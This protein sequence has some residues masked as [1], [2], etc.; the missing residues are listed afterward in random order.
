[1]PLT[2]YSNTENTAL[3]ILKRKGY[4]IWFETDLESFCCEKDGWDFT[5]GGAT[6]LLGVVAFHEYH[7]PKE[8]KEYWWRIEEP[9]LLGNLPT[10]PEPF[11]PVSR[12]REN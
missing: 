9:K 3:I 2:A 5:A 7:Q 11:V 12:R 8:F 10:E 4:Q 1:M 6:E